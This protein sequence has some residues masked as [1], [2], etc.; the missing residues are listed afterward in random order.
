MSK[1]K[2]YRQRAGDRLKVYLIHLS[3]LDEFVRE[4]NIEFYSGIGVSIKYLMNVIIAVIDLLKPALL[5]W[6]L[7]VMGRK[8]LS[9]MS[10]FQWDRKRA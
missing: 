5:V 7:R 3:Y 2:K 8:L 1:R 6:T 4:K 9:L 10:G